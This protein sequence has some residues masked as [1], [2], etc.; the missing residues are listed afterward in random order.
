[1]KSGIFI[2]LLSFTLLSSNVGFSQRARGPETMMLR[3]TAHNAPILAA[4]LKR[5]DFDIAGLDLSRNTVSMSSPRKRVE[6]FSNSKRTSNVTF[7]RFYWPVQT[8]TFTVTATKQGYQ[9]QKATVQVGQ[10][11]ASVEIALTKA[12][13]SIGIQHSVS[14]HR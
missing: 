10:G 8:G 12:D 1:M 4:K 3:L 6:P 13:D 9:P 14:W 7:G 11:N 5:L 2:A